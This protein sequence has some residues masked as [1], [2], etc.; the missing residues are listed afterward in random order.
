MRSGGRVRRQVRALARHEGQ[1]D[2]AGEVPCHV[3]A[4]RLPDREPRGLPRPVDPRGVRAPDGGDAGAAGGGPDG[5]QP[6]PAV[7]VE[8]P[9]GG[10]RPAGPH[11]HPGT[12]AG[13]RLAGGRRAGDRGDRPD[14]AV[15]PAGLGASG[16]SR[17]SSGSWTTKTSERKGEQRP[18]TNPTNTKLHDRALRYMRSPSTGTVEDSSSALF[19]VGRL[20]N[21]PSAPRPSGGCGWTGT[22]STSRSWSP[23][24]WSSSPPVPAGVVVDAT[25]GGGGHAA[26][27]LAARPDLGVLGL[28]RDPAALAAAAGRLAPFGPRAVLQ[29][30]RFA[31]LDRG[32]RR[33]PGR[34]PG[35][36]G[37]RP[38]RRP[39]AD[40]QS[41][42]RG[43]CSISGVSSLA[44]R[45]GRAR[46][47]L[48]PRRRRSTCAW[49]RRGPTAP[50]SWSTRPTR[51]SWPAGSAASGEGRLARRIA[52]AIVAARPIAT[53]AELAEVVGAAVPAA[54]RRRGHP[55]RRVF[56][57]I[58]IA[59]NDESDELAGGLPAALGLLGPGGRCLVISYHSGEGR[60]V[61]E[62]FADGRD[63]RVR[64]PARAAVR[65]RRGRSTSGGSSGARAAVARP[66]C[67][68]RRASSARLWAVERLGTGD[69]LDVTPPAA[70]PPPSRPARPGPGSRPTSAT[71][72]SLPRPR[73]APRRRRRGLAVWS[74][75]LL[76]VGALLARSVVAHAMLAQGQVRLTAA[77]SQLAAEQAIQPPA[78]R[79]VAAAG[80]P[81]PDRR[82]GEEA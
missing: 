54:A 80:E 26:A 71:S 68:Q 40:P 77:Q 74:P 16:C 75:S 28:D 55:A 42:S 11:G 19:P 53:T 1:G 9:G 62:V 78:A 56:Q 76:V 36:A 21:T 51:P 43:S 65:L 49:T 23:R 38:A 29:H 20:G 22:P 3:R 31:D 58:R 7:G 32:G 44:A 2:P 73:R 33:G 52:R 50:S 59:V 72:R 13:V 46:L 41:R 18:D 8:L 61:K 69:E 63:G 60:L 64:L 15:E 17:P 12:A 67:R 45:P 57:A 79:S 30:A 25:V 5:P 35:R 37:P 39:A 14:R 81:G 47:L 48:S 4:G 27:L 82:R 34:R 24:S 6:G 10:G 70:G 66:R